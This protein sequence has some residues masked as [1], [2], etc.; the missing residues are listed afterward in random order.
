M[1]DNEKVVQ[2]IHQ[3]CRLIESLGQELQDTRAWARLWKQAAKESRALCRFWD[4]VVQRQLRAID[5]L[6]AENQR[7]KGESH[8]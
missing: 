1:D 6:E 2:R 4:I 8:E 7:L 5:R 3:M